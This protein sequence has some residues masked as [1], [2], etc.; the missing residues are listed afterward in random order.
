MILGQRRDTDPPVRPFAAFEIWKPVQQLAELPAGRSKFRPF[1]PTR[2]TAAVAGMVRHAVGEA[3]QL[4]RPD[5]E[6]FRSTFVLGH[7]DGH[8]GQAKTD[9]RFAFLPLPS[10]ER[11]GPKDGPRPVHV[12][13][14]RRVLVSGP[15]GSEA[16]RDW[17]R[18]ALS[19]RELV[20]ENGGRSAA[21][22]SVVPSGDPNVTPYTGRSAVWSTVTPV[23]LPGR[24][25]RD[26]AKTERLLRSAIRQAGFP[27]TLAAYAR[28]EWR[29][30]GFLPGVDLAGR[31]DPPAH[32]RNRGF[33]RLHVRIYWC[34]AGGR[35][36]PVGGPIAIGAGR[37]CGLGVFVADDK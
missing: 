33:P 34:D 20:E 19:G 13:M 23:I 37:Y 7:G 11:R 3:A 17:V 29:S 1:D 22:L 14:I 36:V 25:D 31:Y 18:R 4:S 28:L 12:G 9:R 16:D 27:E 6:G 35:P 32:L 15:P 8:S 10:L 24:D 30:A 5:D 21:V 26:P 2:R